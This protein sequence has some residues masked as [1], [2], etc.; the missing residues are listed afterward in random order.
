MLMCFERRCI[1][2]FLQVILFGLIAFSVYEVIHRIEENKIMSKVNSYMNQKNEKYYESFLKNYEKSKKIKMTDRF[3]LMYQLNLLIDRAGL[4]RSIFINPGMLI[5]YSAICAIVAYHM[6]FQFLKIPTLSLIVALPS[7]FIPAL[8]LNTIVSFQE[9]KLEKV[10]LNFLLQI[11]NYTKLSNDITSA[12]KEVD[13][14]EPL[15][16]H[17][18]KFNI[19]LGSGI[20]F[21]VAMEH[22]KEKISIRK[23]KEFFSNI[24]YCYLYGGSFPHLI[25]K[26]YQMISEIQTEKTKR[27]QETKGARIVLLILMILNIY[28]YITYIK[29]NYENYLIMQKST[30]GMMILYWNFISMWILLWLS[31]RV[32]KLDY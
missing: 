4:E 32:K 5:L 20:K 10:F 28:V 7:V 26:N 24:Q 27:M 2:F 17:I 8:I 25:D 15:K 11:K 14:I 13:T 30:L 22:L 18:Q 3:H 16:T 31:M 19:E 9:E 23:F 21:E 12:F 1:M 6:V 29:S